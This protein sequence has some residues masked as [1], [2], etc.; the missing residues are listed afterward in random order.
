[1]VVKARSPLV[2][3]LTADSP[4]IVLGIGLVGTVLIALVVETVARR[5][6]AAIALYEVEH[7]VAESLQR[8]LLPQLP[9]LPGLDLAARYLASGAGQQVG[10]DWFDAFPVA[11]G[12]C[13]LVVG[14][15]I[16]HDVA[17]AGAMAQIRALLRGYAVDGDSPAA[18]LTRLDRIVDEL[19]LTQ[20]VTVFY[21]LLEPPAADGSRLLRYSNAGHVPPVM[22]RPDGSVDSLAG[23]A[24]VVMGAPIVS[25]YAEGEAVIF[26]GSTLTLFTDGLVEVPGESLTDGLERVAQTVAGLDDRSPD[27]LCDDLLSEVSRHALRDDVA[28]LVVRLSGSVDAVDGAGRPTTHASS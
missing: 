5:R 11:G 13:G 19:H 12:R 6:D 18:V 21:G 23:G 22:R 27:A 4:W 3:R 24:S 9:D 28:L 20:L 1:M 17:A 10:G 25:D 2:G 15:V 7:Q 8:S 16:G 26:P 14:D